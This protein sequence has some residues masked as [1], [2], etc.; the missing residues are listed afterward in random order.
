MS[1]KYVKPMIAIVPDYAEGVYAASGNKQG[2]LDV[3]YSG[4]W[5]NGMVVEKFLPM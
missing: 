2:Q 1:K 3:T 4:V 5:D